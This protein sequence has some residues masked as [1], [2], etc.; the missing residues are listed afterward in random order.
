MATNPRVIP[1][2]KRGSRQATYAAVPKKSYSASELRQAGSS[3]RGS[4][5]SGW[6]GFFSHTLRRTRVGWTVLNICPKCGLMPPKDM[7]S[8]AHRRRFMFV[9]AVSAH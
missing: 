2:Y 9:H 5:E 8:P 3:L 4:L 1:I 6:E 7:H